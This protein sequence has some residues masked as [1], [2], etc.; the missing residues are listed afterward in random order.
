MTEVD[1]PVESLPEDQ[2]PE[3]LPDYVDVVDPEPWF[4]LI[5]DR[6]GIPRADFD[7][8][9][10][11]RP[12]KKSLNI[13]PADHQPPGRP[14]PD[15]IGLR[16][17]RTAMRHPKITTAAAMAFGR[18]AT[19]NA[20]DLTAEQIDRYASRRRVVLSEEGAE[21]CTDTGYVLVGHRGVILGVGLFFTD[22]VG[23]RLQ[24]MYP[25]AWAVDPA[26]SIA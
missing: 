7:D 6:F 17:I 24:S 16:F 4:G 26:V 3:H 11:H 23:G 14:E 18:R 1:Q 21:P 15:A 2:R 10:L 8:F 9:L 5:C 19:R 13:V 20:V 22:E 12:S 25:K